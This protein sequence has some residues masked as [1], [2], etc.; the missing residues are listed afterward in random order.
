MKI[1]RTVLIAVVAVFM[2]LSANAQFEK[3]ASHEDLDFW[4]FKLQLQ[5]YVKTKNVEGLKQLLAD[6]IY[7]SSHDCKFDDC[8][9]DN[10]IVNHFNEDAE[11]S[12]S[13]LASILR[14]GFSKN[15]NQDLTGPMS[16]QETT[17]KGPSYLNEIDPDNELIVLAENVN[18]RRYP[19]LDAKIIGKASYEKFEC[20]CNVTTMDKDAYQIADGISW[21]KI[22]LTNGQTGYVASKYTSFEMTR[23]LTVGK[24]DGE[25]KIVSFVQPPGC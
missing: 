2:T 21:I 9:K 18:I 16:I 17:F 23:E 20:D 5:D 1:M 8:S 15:K 24:V 11:D 19:A 3:D 12:W 7:Q 14:F 6:N 4:K 22:R 13:V 25:W 10:F